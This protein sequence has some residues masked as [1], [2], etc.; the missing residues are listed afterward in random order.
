M[1][2]LDAGCS[3]K[4]LSEVCWGFLSGIPMIEP[5]VLILRVR[6]A[7]FARACCGEFASLSQAIRVAQIAIAAAILIHLFSCV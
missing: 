4:S 2:V 3:A 1:P 5:G 6:I 7:L